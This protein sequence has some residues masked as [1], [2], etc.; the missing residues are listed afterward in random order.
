MQENN[1]AAHRAGSVI[2]YSRVHFSQRIRL[3]INKTLDYDNRI[4]YNRVVFHIGRKRG[5][6]MYYHRHIEPVVARIAKRKSVLVLTGARQVGKSTMLKEVYKGIR[7]ISF[8]RL[9]VRES[10]KDNPLKLILYHNS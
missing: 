4:G 8:N 1:N 7:Y 3:K 5:L 2:I 9:L 10:A 6:N